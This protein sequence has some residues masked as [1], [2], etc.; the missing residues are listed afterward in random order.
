LSRYS[1]VTAKQGAA[2]L[3]LP[4]HDARVIWSVWQGRAYERPRCTAQELADYCRQT[5]G[6]VPPLVVALVADERDWPV[7][8]ADLEHE[9]ATHSKRLAHTRAANAPK[10]AAAKTWDEAVKI[11]ET[12]PDLEARGRLDDH[13]L[14][15]ETD[16]KDHWA[17]ARSYDDGTE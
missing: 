8:L 3:G 14:P 16:M 4:L 5:Y 10:L 6:R 13:E 15:P 9:W 1:W 11:A 7:W 17:L 2:L 12:F